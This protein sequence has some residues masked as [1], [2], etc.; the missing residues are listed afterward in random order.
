[1]AEFNPE[2]SVGLKSLTEQNPLQKYFRQPKVYITLPSKGKFYPEGSLNMPE[3]GELPVMAMTAR[4]E[5]TMKTPDALLNGQA[6]VNLVNS[7]I[8]SIID[9]WQ[10]PSIDMDASL[11]AIRIATYGDQMDI[12][13]KEPGTGEDKSYAVDLRQLLNKLVTVQYNNIIN[14]NDMVVTIRPLTYKEFSDSSLATFEE[15]RIFQLVNDDAVEDEEKLA[16]F[17]QSFKKL[18]DLTVSVLSKSISTI[19][20]GDTVVSDQKHIDEFIANTDKDF[21]KEIT[22]H[23]ESERDKF[24]LEPVKVTSTPEDIEAGAPPEWEIPITFDQSNFFA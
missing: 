18:T 5:L 24:T 3:T 11:I 1:M 7:C 8:P 13:T 9:P 16:K 23:L 19:Q 2:E 4:D 15:Q 20:I 17:N 14:I 12:S 6:T 21:F 22:K 10:M